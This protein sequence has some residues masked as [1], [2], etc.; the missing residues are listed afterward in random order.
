VVIGTSLEVFPA[1]KLFHMCKN[2][3]P[4]Y[5]INPQTNELIGRDNLNYI[6]EKATIGMEILFEKLTN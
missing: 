1:S 4:K 2:E 6:Q 3:I 5:I